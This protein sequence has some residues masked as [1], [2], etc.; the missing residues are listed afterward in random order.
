MTKVLVKISDIYTGSKY[1]KLHSELQLTLQQSVLSCA[2]CDCT[3]CRCG[4]RRKR[5]TSFCVGVFF[6]A[7]TRQKSTLSS[8]RPHSCQP[9]TVPASGGGPPVSAS[10]L[11]HRTSAFAATYAC[12]LLARQQFRLAGRPVTRFLG[13]ASAFG[14]LGA[15][16]YES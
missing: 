7:R 4:Q 6:P 5:R 14:I 10:R 8:P 3:C 2:E 13:P 1:G 16:G 12:S 9:A 15:S 11:R